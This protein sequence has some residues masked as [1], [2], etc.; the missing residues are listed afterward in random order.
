MVDLALF[1]GMDLIYMRFVKW[2][3]YSYQRKIHNFEK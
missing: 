2:F 1:Q 3:N